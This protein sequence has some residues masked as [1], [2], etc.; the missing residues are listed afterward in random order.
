M[1]NQQLKEDLKYYEVNSDEDIN[2]DVGEV[3]SP[4]DRGTSSNQK[5]YGIIVPHIES[6][7]NIAILKANINVAEVNSE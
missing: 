3:T 5:S 4:L 1:Q 2:N 7:S 6:H